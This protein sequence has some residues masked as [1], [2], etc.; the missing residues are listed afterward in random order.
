MICKI[1]LSR[2]KSN[3]RF[4]IHFQCLI[5]AYAD[6]MEPNVAFSRTFIDSIELN[7]RFVKL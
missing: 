2:K 6:V 5:R 3:I 7:W 1:E 4:S